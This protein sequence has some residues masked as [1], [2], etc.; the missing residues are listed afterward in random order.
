MLHNIYLLIIDELADKHDR[1]RYF[2]CLSPST[3]QTCVHT[4]R[5]ERGIVA[6]YPMPHPSTTY[7]Q[8]SV[9][10]TLCGHN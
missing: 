9:L 10:L 8:L 6:S 5:V 3:W 4:M 2:I 1:I 7:T